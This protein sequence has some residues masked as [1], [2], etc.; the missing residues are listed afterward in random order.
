M[1]QNV[2]G[3][4]LEEITSESPQSFLTTETPSD[5]FSW[6][7]DWLLHEIPGMSIAV[8]VILITDYSVKK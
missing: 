8:Q 6:E 4:I 3:R 1:K 5:V 7:S 2:L